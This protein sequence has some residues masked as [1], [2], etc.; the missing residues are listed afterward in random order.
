MNEERDELKLPAS[1]F[2]VAVR[3]PA[4]PLL[5][6]L[7]QMRAPSGL[8]LA[9]FCGQILEQAAAEFRMLRI[10]PKIEFSADDMPLDRQVRRKGEGVLTQRRSLP[11]EKIQ[12]LLA[13]Y[14]QGVQPKELAERFSISIASAS[15]ICVRFDRGRKTPLKA[16]T[17]H[18]GE[19]PALP[20]TR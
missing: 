19:A 3:M 5:Q 13:A 16:P 14:V 2:W 7:H 18:R 9:A 4:K 10:T 17:R 1:C 8:P 20:T 12:R 11:P 15:R 6:T